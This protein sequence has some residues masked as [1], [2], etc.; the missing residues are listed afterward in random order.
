MSQII[1][2]ALCGAAL[3]SSWW[4]LLAIPPQPTHQVWA[5]PILTTAFAI[6]ALLALCIT[7]WEKP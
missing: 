4:A 5:L 2:G 3:A 7:N 1:V 6:V